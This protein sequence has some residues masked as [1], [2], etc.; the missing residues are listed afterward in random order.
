MGPLSL[1]RVHIASV[2]ACCKTVTEC[3]FCFLPFL[4][5][6][7]ILFGFLLSSENKYH[8][9]PFVKSCNSDFQKL[10]DTRVWDGS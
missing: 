1:L 2:M 8:C 4:V 10:R 7:R 9:R 3:Y 5:K 6:A